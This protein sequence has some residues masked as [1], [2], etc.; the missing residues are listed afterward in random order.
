MLALL[1]SAAN[2]QIASAVVGLVVALV[3]PF[4][5]HVDTTQ[6]AGAL[7]ALGVIAKTIELRLAKPAVVSQAPD[8]A[9][10]SPPVNAIDQAVKVILDA[11]AALA[12]LQPAPVV[13]SSPAVGETHM[14]AGAEVMPAPVVAPV[15]TSQAA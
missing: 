12:R 13:P 8:P 4:G 7:V 15:E 9:P 6:L 10:G 3:Q 14:L 11:N 5:A 2:I 1:A